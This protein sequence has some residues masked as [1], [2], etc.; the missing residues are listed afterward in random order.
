MPAT[1]PAARADTSMAYDPGTT[2]LV[3]FG[4][5]GLPESQ[6]HLNYKVVGSAVDHVGRQHH[7][8]GRHRGT[9]QATASGYP[10]P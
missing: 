2:Q 5:D 9:F 1:N 4:G 8:P 7:L 3:L 6:R 10:T